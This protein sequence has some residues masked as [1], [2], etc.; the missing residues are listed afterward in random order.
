MDFLF[1]EKL[2]P[3]TQFMRPDGRQVEGEIK[4]DNPD[5]HRRAS[6]LLGLGYRFTL[7]VLTTGQVSLAIEGPLPEMEDEEGDI[8][9]SV[10]RQSPGALQ[11]GLARAVA[12]AESALA[13]ARG[14]A[15]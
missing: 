1:D 3:A 15:A 6:A 7:E 4:V 13:K 8:A 14:E 11:S 2:I 10:F 9:I 5:T 12:E